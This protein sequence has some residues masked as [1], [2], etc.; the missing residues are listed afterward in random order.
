MQII[1]LLMVI[2]Y[3]IKPI[4]IPKDIIYLIE[5]QDVTYIFYFRVLYNFFKFWS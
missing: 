4:F 5:R 3:H 1:F 2:S